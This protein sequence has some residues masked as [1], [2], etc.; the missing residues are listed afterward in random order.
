[1]FASHQHYNPSS[2]PNYYQKPLR[3]KFNKELSLHYD[4]Q[5]NNHLVMVEK[6]ALIDQY[7]GRLNF[8]FN[9]A[10][11]QYSKVF[12]IRLDLRFSN[13]YELMQRTESDVITRFIESLKAKIA[14]NRML[15]RRNGNY[16]DTEVRYVWAKEISKDASHHYHVL[17]FLNGNAFRSLGSFEMGNDNL[18]NRINEAWAS[19]LS[20]HLVQASGLVHVSDQTLIDQSQ[21]DAQERIDH[22]FY[23]GSYL[24]KAATK[25]Y[26][27]GGKWFGSSRK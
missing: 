8:V 26:D 5:Y 6:G 1:M 20:I 18:Y 7:L 11:T 22:V 17:L 9:N 3:H 13:D 4:Q 21:M 24:C 2:N 27:D 23:L 14:H 16:H 25:L 12:T 15:A 19:A 10:L